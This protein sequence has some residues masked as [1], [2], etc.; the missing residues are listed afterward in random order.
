M[1]HNSTT[2]SCSYKIE[3]KYKNLHTHHNK[4]NKKIRSV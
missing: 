3:K 4:G 1:K 2:N